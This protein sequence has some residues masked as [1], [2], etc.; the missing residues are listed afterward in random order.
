MKY[1]I[2]VEKINKINDAKGIFDTKRFSQIITVKTS[3]ENI[4]EMLKSKGL[5]IIAVEA[6]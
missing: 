6:C 1:K 4:I 2:I 3:I 5:D